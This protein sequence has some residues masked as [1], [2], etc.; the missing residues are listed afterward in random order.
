LTPSLAGDALLDWS[1]YTR[2]LLATSRLEGG[3]RLNPSQ[4]KA[5]EKAVLADRLHVCTPFRL[6]A[7]FSARTAKDFAVLSE[8]LDGFRQAPADA[9]TW[10]FAERAQR[11]L[12]EDPAVNHRVKLADLLVAAIASQHRLGVLHYDADYDLISRHSELDFESVWIAPRG[13]VD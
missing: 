8:D 11:D 4:M 3:K 9:D 12:A 10:L 1:A 2:V 5:F 13:S 7:R 6:E